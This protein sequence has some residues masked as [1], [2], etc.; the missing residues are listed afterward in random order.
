[1]IVFLNDR[2]FN[3]N[4]DMMEIFKKVKYGLLE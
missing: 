2:D 1:M 3:F 4:E